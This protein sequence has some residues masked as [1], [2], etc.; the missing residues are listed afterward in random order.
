M[1]KSS[2]LPRHG[3]RILVTIFKSFDIFSWDPLSIVQQTIVAMKNDPKFNSHT[4]FPKRNATFKK[5]YGIC[6]SCNGISAISWKSWED[7]YSD[8]WVYWQNRLIFFDGVFCLL[9]PGGFSLVHMTRGHWPWSRVTMK[10]LEIKVA[11]LLGKSVF[12][13]WNLHS[14]NIHYA[15]YDDLDL[16]E[17][18]KQ[19]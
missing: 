11:F 14:I 18:G 8:Y 12:L 15:W 16:M 4:L 19:C 6:I 7:V 1:T 17:A 2:N 3:L 5:N 10:N 13:C 9:L